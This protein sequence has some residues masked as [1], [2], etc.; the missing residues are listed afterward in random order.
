MRTFQARPERR[1][2][3]GFTLI[4]LLVVIGIIAILAAL[5]TPAIIGAMRKA[6][7]TETVNLI[8]QVEIA[9]QAYFND[10]GDYPPTTW[11][12]LVQTM[13]LDLTGDGASDNADLLR[14]QD[15]AFFINGR[16]D[17]QNAG[18]EVL[19]ACL[20]TN[21]G[22][23]YLELG[24]RQLGNTDGDTDDGSIGSALNWYFGGNELFELV[25]YW[26]NPLVYIHNRNYA[27]VDGWRDD[28]A[29]AI[30]EDPTV[31]GAAEFMLYVDVDGNT[32]PCYG[33]WD[34]HLKWDPLVS[35]WVP[36]P[37]GEY[38]ILRTMNYPNLSAF[39][40]YSWGPDLQ[41]G[42]A[43]SQTTPGTPNPNELGQ[44]PGWIA[45]SRNLVNWQE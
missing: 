44:W 25:D 6:Q 38:P 30:F 27:N 36:W 19:V 45:K 39:Q 34:D 20:A 2:H 8:H 5:I 3:A 14:L 23:P 21:T 43:E 31:A 28:W 17:D 18:I 15:L 33:R 16:P 42:C 1:N 22:G 4:E 26:G 12:G 41:P 9:A 40:L 35:A 13:Q 29:P 11:A 32:V 7:E 10:R 24:P 37:S